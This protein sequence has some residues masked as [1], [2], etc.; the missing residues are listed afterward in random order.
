MESNPSNDD[1]FEQA[2]SSVS[3]GIRDALRDLT[4]DS[5]YVEPR[6]VTHLRD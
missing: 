3:P 1:A 5:S 2:L 6:V 4:A